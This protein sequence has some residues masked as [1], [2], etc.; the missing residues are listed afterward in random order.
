M[1]KIKNII[2]LIFILLVNSCARRERNMDAVVIFNGQSFNGVETEYYFQENGE[3]LKRVLAGDSKI[4]LKKDEEIFKSLKKYSFNNYQPLD[5]E[6]NEIIIVTKENQIQ[7]QYKY[8]TK[9]YSLV[10]SLDK[11]SRPLKVP[12][13]P[14]FNGDLVLTYI[15]KENDSIPFQELQLLVF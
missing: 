1:F 3:Y 15:V 7:N 14:L 8:D 5:S 11:R 2:I 9:L 13:N 10:D 6:S 4:A 12:M